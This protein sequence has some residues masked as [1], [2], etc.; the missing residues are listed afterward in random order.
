VPEPH[1][2][3][4]VWLWATIA[5]T[6]AAFAA[7]VGLAPAA[8]APP[9]RGLDW[10]LFIGSS[11]HVASNGWFYTLR[12]IRSHA[13]SRPWR[14]RR[15]PVALV[16]AGAAA[17]ALL[18]G[19]VVTW[20][21]LPF[22]GWQFLHFQKQNLGLA[23]LAASSG[24]TPGL[25]PAE[26]RALVAS[27]AAGIFALLARPALLQLPVNPRLGL[28]FPL[29]ALAFGLAVVAGLAL[30]ARRQATDRPAG[31]C[32]A[33]LM[34]L[35]FS[36]P[37][38]VFASPYAAVGGMTIAHG[39]QYLLLAGLV[40]AGD[41]RPTSR[42]LRLAALGNIAVVGGAVLEATSH[43]HGA[44]PAGRLLFGA[45]LGAVMAHFVI[46][47]GLW[48]LRDP[49]PRAFLSERVPYLVLPRVVPVLHQETPTATQ[50]F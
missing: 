1:R 26:R 41:P 35:L 29:S 14:F 38:F 36:L 3:A 19:P 20:L 12:D 40:A 25:R 43:L 39:L 42:T 22:F 27:G 16:L 24:G 18:P 32:V 49:F 34:A 9:G 21:L 2:A 17:A 44:V 6:S 8:P 13:A 15:A 37:V 23:A 46:D 50:E 4:R 45:Y 33:Y 11:A 48:R 5:L 30:L 47:A 7:A 28:L 31:F 10:L